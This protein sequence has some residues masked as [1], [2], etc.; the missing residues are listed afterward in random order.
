MDNSV[1]YWETEQPQVAD[2]GKQRFS[3]YKEAG[4]LEVASIIHEDGI[5]KAIRRQAL[6]AA[7]LRKNEAVAN[8]LIDFLASAGLIQ[9]LD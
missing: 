7:K 9:E 4:V 8:M 5:Q 6:S 3:F 2:A 1:P